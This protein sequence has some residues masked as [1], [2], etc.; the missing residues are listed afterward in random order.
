MADELASVARQESTIEPSKYLL[1]T[2]VNAM[3]NINEMPITLK[4]QECIRD[5]YWTNKLFSYY[6]S[7]FH[8]EDHVIQQIHWTSFDEA[9]RKLSHSDIQ[10]IQKYNI[11]HLHSNVREQYFHPHK[12]PLCPSCN[13]CIET[14]YHIIQ[15]QAKNRQ[16]CITEWERSI[17]KYLSQD[18]TPLYSKNS[19]NDWFTIVASKQDK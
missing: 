7:K 16:Q 11:N 9:L 12:S 15:C 19:I 1:P 4:Y 6:E 3:L 17:L 2:A 14:N 18:H 8:W 5:A 10:R 13:C